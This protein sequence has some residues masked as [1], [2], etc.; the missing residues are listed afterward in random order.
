MTSSLRV[1]LA[2]L[3]LAFAPLL[4]A[5]TDSP[6]LWKIAGPKANVYLFGSFHL[7]PP[8]V[9]WRTQRVGMALDEAKV[10]VLEIDPASAQDQQQMMQLILKHG[11]L[12]Q[13]QTLPA[14]LPPKLNAELERS[15]T[16][17]GVPPASLAPMRPWLAGVTLAVQ[18]IVSQGYDPNAG[19]DH[20]IAAWARQSGRQI[21]ALETAEAQLRIFADLTRE[22]EIEM[23]AVS[24]KQIR[25]T[26]QM[27]SQMLAAYRAGDVASLER[28]LNA[29]FDE[30]PLLR[31]RMLRDRHDQ[32]LPQIQRMIADGRSHFIVV[33][34]AH[35]AG[36][37]GVIAMLRAKGIKVEG[38]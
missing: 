6:A 15:A 11:V 29:G 8:K 38:P 20:Q 19:V 33:G 14:V 27:L 32:W 34:A 26:P 30:V 3:T 1:L 18:F 24:L 35:L 31:K 10:I 22:Q 7:L 9:H 28:S 13:G 4:A 25:E 2:L 23:L 21:A 12:P 16:A 5:Q 17:L 36:R 37:D